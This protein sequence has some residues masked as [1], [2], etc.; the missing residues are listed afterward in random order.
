MEVVDSIEALLTRLTAAST[1]A[2]AQIHTMACLDSRYGAR[3]L[4][5]DLVTDRL[6]DYRG[7]VKSMAAQAADLLLSGSKLKF[8]SPS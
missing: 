5:P 1:A 6:H 2:R 8:T 4:A 7:I 3:R